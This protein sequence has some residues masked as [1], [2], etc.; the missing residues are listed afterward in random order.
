MTETNLA[1]STL[2]FPLGSCRGITHSLTR[3][4][5]GNVIRNV[6]G[7]ALDLTRP[8]FQKYKLSVSVSDTS[9]ATLGGIWKGAAV[10]VDCAIP[11]RHKTTTTSV[12]LERDPVSGSVRAYLVSDG[13]SISTSVVGRVVTLAAFVGVAVVEYRPALSC[14]VLEVS[15]SFDE[16]AGSESWSLDLEEA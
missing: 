1:I 11:L 9:T 4:D 14:V 2:A 12:T 3:L 10:S 8:G 7:A 16:W 5:S 13:S 15:Q 6:N